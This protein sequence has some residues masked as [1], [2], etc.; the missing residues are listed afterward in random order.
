MSKAKRKRSGR[1]K[2]QR[3]RIAV[4][5]SGAVWHQ[6]AEEATLAQKPHFNG[7]ACGHGTHGDTRYNRTR[8]KRAWKKQLRQEGASRGLLP[9]K[10]LISKSVFC[11]I[12]K[13]ENLNSHRFLRK[14]KCYGYVSTAEN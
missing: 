1:P 8:E 5:K 4:A 12:N 3:K 14:R 2:A 7:Y 9:Y 11:R 10:W 13:S 6:S